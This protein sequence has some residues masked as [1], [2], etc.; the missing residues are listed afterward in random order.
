[1]TYIQ[2][3]YNE[4]IWHKTAKNNKF[5]NNG[6]KNDKIK[7]SRVALEQQTNYRI[8]YTVQQYRCF[9]NIWRKSI[10]RQH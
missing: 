5:Y 3:Q 4:Q 7:L 8:L 9:W 1:M 6:N 10:L 2:Q